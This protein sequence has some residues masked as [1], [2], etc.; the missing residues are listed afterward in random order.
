MS[1][2]LIKD[3]KELEPVSKKYDGDLHF[4]SFIEVYYR[5]NKH[6]KTSYEPEKREFLKERREALKR[7]DTAKYEET[8][9]KMA[10]REEDLLNADMMAAMDYLGY[11]KKDYDA[12]YKGF[13]ENP[14]T[15]AALIQAQAKPFQT[16][17]KK[18]PSMSIDRAKKIYIYSEEAKTEAL[19][20]LMKQGVNIMDANPDKETEQ[21]MLL[22]QARLSDQM[23]AKWGVDEDEFCFAMIHYNLM[24]DP[25]LVQLTQDR[26]Q[27]LGQGAKPSKSSKKGKNKKSVEETKGVED[28]GD[29]W[30]DEEGEAEE[31]EKELAKR[32][33]E[34]ANKQKKL[35][36]KM[37]TEIE[38]CGQV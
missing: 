13:M 8:V 1:I 5:V 3:I 9:I 23:H 4:S 10:K 16:G 34:V 22:Q 14:E 11:L 29:D 37:K 26:M 17:S 12:M 27:K 21:K 33:K 28:D 24:A 7:N 36:K 38:A 31:F 30:G 25:E 35:V 20:T 32:K 6:A 2:E 15:Q 18:G 19:S